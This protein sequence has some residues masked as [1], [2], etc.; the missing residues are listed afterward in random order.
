MFNGSVFQH[1]QCNRRRGEESETKRICSIW[2]TSFVPTSLFFSTQ[3]TSPLFHKLW[4]SFFFH[5]FSMAMISDIE[6]GEISSTPSPSRLL[7]PRC[8]MQTSSKAGYCVIRIKSHTE[9]RNSRPPLLTTS[10]NSSSD[11]D[12]A[13]SDTLSSHRPNENPRRRKL[14]CYLR[15]ANPPLHS[16]WFI[17]FSAKFIQLI[18]WAFD[19]V[20]SRKK[21]RGERKVFSA[22]RCLCLFAH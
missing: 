7:L 1:F 20:K 15:E 19:D 9:K 13:I 8:L 21:R 5:R 10:I 14:F 11:R 17:Y 6:T 18:C 2:K 12:A 3:K 16:Q 22:H 4:L